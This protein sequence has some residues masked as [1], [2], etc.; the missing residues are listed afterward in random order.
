MNRRSFLQQS[1]LLASG[2]VLG[3][4][5]SKG[6]LAANSASMQLSV[7]VLTTEPVRAVG[8]IEALIQ[9][10]NLSLKNLVYTDYQLLGD[11]V[12]D[13]VVTTN[14]QLLDYKKQNGD[15]AQNIA[16]ISQ[17]LGLPAQVQNPSRLRIA[18]AVPGQK[19]EKIHIFHKNTLLAE[20]DIR[21]NNE[22]IDIPASHGNLQLSVQNGRA[23]LRTASCKH[24]TCVKM[25]SIARPGEQIVCIPNEI[26]ISVS[27]IRSSGVDSL[28]F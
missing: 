10:S 11:Y 6:L 2:I 17:S 7:D 9:N 4:W 18:T 22:V 1:A 26:R 28:A 20:L 24:K 25:G 12:G 21:E 15:F 14:G 27:G 16:E 3:S 13:I 19:A 23:K 5:N 8:L